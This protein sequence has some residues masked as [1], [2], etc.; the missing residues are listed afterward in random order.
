LPDPAIYSQQEQLA[1]GTQPSWDSPDIVTNYLHPWKLML[2]SKVIVRNLSDQVAAVN[3]LV[4]LSISSFGIGMQRTPVS[5][6][7][8]TLDRGEV[9]SLLYPLPQTILNGD[10]LVSAFVDIQHST[11]RNRINNHGEQAIAGVETSQ[12]GRTFDLTLPVRN[13]TSAARTMLLEA[14]GNDIGATVAPA[15]HAFGPFQQI[16]ATVH[17][18]VPATLHGTP[19][20]P[21]Q[22]SVTIIARTPSGELLGGVTYRVRIDS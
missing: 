13:S 10:Q 16:T 2:E 1:N 21:L 8:I 15:S 22:K 4:Q 3:T 11:D 19:H 14:L 18:V 9:R 12:A 6:Q 5:S 17:A 7:L 20:A